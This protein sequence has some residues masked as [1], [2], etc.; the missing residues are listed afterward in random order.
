MSVEPEATMS[1]K[2][3]CQPVNAVWLLDHYPFG[4]HAGQYRWI[5]SLWESAQRRGVS[6]R[7]L[8]P[9][10]A[11]LPP[12]IHLVSSCVD[13]RA[14]LKVGRD[15]AVADPRIWLRRLSWHL[16]RTLPQR[17]EAW[18]ANLRRRV[19]RARGFDHV[20]GS[21]LKVRQRAWAVKRLKEL[22]PDVV[23][24]G[25]EFMI[26]E[27]P[28]RSTRM[29]LAHDV[30]SARCRAMGLAGYVARPKVSEAWERHRLSSIDAIVAIQWDDAATFRRLVPQAEV[31]VAP[32]SFRRATRPEAV[33][34]TRR[35]LLVGSGTLH[36]VDGARWFLEE[37]WG[38][39]RQAVAD[40]RLDVVGSVGSQLTGGPAPGAHIAGEVADLRPSYEAAQIV[41]AP[42]RY[43]SGLNVKVAEALAHGRPVVTSPAGAQ[44]LAGLAGC[45]IVVAATA[46]EFAGA[47]IRLLR[48]REACDELARESWEFA[49][50]FEAETAHAGFLARVLGAT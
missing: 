24:F 46:E 27:T 7:M 5:E 22:Q 45:P 25:S 21:E 36:N 26:V 23:I 43:G 2:R 4:G 39:I 49:A 29:V 11:G 12:A 16:Y 44:G 38:A 41:V 13:S 31:L 28:P 6:N 30:V 18:V 14:L 33:A 37:V 17:T 9:S 20:M 42:L 35:C 50:V 3:P 40:C 10:G 32:P 8:L 19:R 48:D 47:V 34:P 15:W 1:K